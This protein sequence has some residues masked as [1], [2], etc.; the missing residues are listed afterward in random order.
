M[1]LSKSL[2]KSFNSLTKLNPI[3]FLHPKNYDLYHWLLALR[4][5]YFLILISLFYFSINSLFALAYMTAEDGIANAEQGSFKD[6]FFFSIQTL[7]TVGYGSMYPQT[8]YAQILVT[9][10]IWLGL[11]LLTILTGLMFARFSRPTAKVIF[12]NV[13][14]ICPYNGIPTLMIRTA[15]RRDNRILEAQIRLCFILNE[16]SE[17]GYKLRRFYDLEL[18][19]SQ[20]PV[21]DLSWLVMHPI[22]HNSPLYGETLESLAEKDGEIGVMLTGL[23]ETFSQTIH[24]RHVYSLVNILPNRRFVDIFARNAQGQTYVNLTHFHDVVSINN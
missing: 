2:I 14:V 19:R 17:E 5:R 13:A 22:D 9:I 8:L 10:E 21:F 16:V 1:R 20:T 15:N 6:A 7:S 18:L 11:L 23:D 4:W 3:T 12:S 24:A